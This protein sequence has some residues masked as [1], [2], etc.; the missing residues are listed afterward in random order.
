MCENPTRTA[1]PDDPK[2]GPFSVPLSLSDY[3]I[4]LSRCVSGR[5]LHFEMLMDESGMITFQGLLQQ[6]PGNIDYQKVPDK[7]TRTEIRS[8]LEFVRVIQLTLIKKV[9]EMDIAEINDLF[10]V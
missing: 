9:D 5:S 8:T 7:F 6:M 10:I 3:G 4:I 2:E 1:P